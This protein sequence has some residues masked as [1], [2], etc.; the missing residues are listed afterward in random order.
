MY[1]H[2]TLPTVNV[3]TEM[4]LQGC[5]D[6]GDKH[7]YLGLRRAASLLSLMSISWSLGPETRASIGSPK[8]SKKLD[9]MSSVFIM[10]VKSCS[11]FPNI[12]QF[13]EPLGFIT[14]LFIDLHSFNITLV[15]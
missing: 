5:G 8:K 3:D 1:V 11:K 7:S 6:S 10:R 15:F 2:S 12:G 4:S 9:P 13:N 14:L